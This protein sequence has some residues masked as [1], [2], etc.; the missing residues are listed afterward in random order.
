M[1]CNLYEPLDGAWPVVYAVVLVH[2]YVRDSDTLLH[3]SSIYVDYVRDIELR[4][5][6]SLPYNSEQSIVHAL[7]LLFYRWK[8]RGN[9]QRHNEPLYHDIYQ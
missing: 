6:R 4:C 9:V 7:H 3:F 8:R 2:Q 1:Y 5:R